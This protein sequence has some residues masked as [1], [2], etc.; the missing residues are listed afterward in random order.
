MIAEVVAA[1][2]AGLG[3]LV[4]LARYAPTQVDRLLENRRRADIMRFLRSNPGACISQLCKEVNLSWG[5]AQ[6]HLFMLERAGLVASQEAGR[7]HAF[8][9]KETGDGLL[10]PLALLRNRRALELS[11][12]ILESPGVRQKELCRK[13]EMTRKVLRHHIGLL[14]AAGLVV[15]RWGPRLRFYEPSGALRAAVE[16]LAGNHG[17]EPIRGVGSGLRTPLQGLPQA[18]AGGS[19]PGG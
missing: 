19:P 18:Q 16:I 2:F 6:H 3:V 14:T 13:L 10:V 9:T 5:S 8:F 4:A 11:Q 1:A 12:A 17:D 15:E 7:N